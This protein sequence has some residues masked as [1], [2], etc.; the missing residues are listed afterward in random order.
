S[1]GTSETT[2]TATTQAQPAARNNKSNTKSAPGVEATE[3]SV[4]FA[5]RRI[6]FGSH[7]AAYLRGRIRTDRYFYTF[8]ALLGCRDRRTEWLGRAPANANNTAGAAIRR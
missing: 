8:A 6:V 7:V 3:G 4:S 5:D 1:P 2:T